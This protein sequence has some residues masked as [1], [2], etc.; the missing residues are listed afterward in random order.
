MQEN[1]SCR[2]TTVK[3]QQVGILAVVRYVATG[4]CR[5][6]SKANQRPLV[7]VSSVL[8]RIGEVVQC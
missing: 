7:S 2:L 1:S 3:E 5:F 4:N 6:L 8:F